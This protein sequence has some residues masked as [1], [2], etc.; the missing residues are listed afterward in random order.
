MQCFMETGLLGE[1]CKDE[2]SFF[3][4]QFVFLHPEL[5]QQLS[6]S[7]SESGLEE[8]ASKDLGGLIARKAITALGDMAIAQPPGAGNEGGRKSC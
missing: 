1:M 3:W 6:A 4:D 2:G 7:Y 8:V 5:L